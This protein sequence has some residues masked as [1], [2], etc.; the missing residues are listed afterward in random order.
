[1][2]KKSYYVISILFLLWTSPLLFAKPVEITLWTDQ[3][4]P[5]RLA[6]I[7]YILN[8]F[9]TMHDQSIKVSIKSYN[10]NHISKAFENA[11]AN[12]KAPSI[13]NANLELLVEF[14]AK[15][16]LEQT[17]VSKLIQKKKSLEFFQG[18]LK[19]AAVPEKK[20]RY[21]AIPYH[22]WLQGIWYRKDWFEKAKLPEPNTLKRIL[23]AAKFFYQPKKKQYGILIGSK[24][25][26]YTEQV[27]TH[28]AKSMGISTIDYKNKI[29]FNSQKTVK[30]LKYYQELNKYAP[31]GKNNWRARDFFFQNKLAMMFYST[32]IM[33]DLAFRHAALNSLTSKNFAE[34]KGESFDANFLNKVGVIS[35]IGETKKASYGVIHGLGVSK[36]LNTKQQD[37][38]NK[39]L[40]FLFRQDVYITWLHM[41]PGGM[42]PIIKKTLE[43]PMF[44]QDPIGLYHRYK[45]EKISKIIHSVDQVVNFSFT[46][47][48]I[49][50]FAHRFS[51]IRIIPRMIDRVLFQKMD[52]KKSVLIASKEMQQELKNK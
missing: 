14:G 49:N 5:T 47:E 24:V 27:F 30:L 46:K 22:S 3:T 34:L 43:S 48:G 20:N 15:G 13:I 23:S 2:R 40:Y 28:L 29:Q 25:D 45:R 16:Y 42:L 26:L 19:I 8:A 37:A 36:N 52:I 41:A 32:H 1:M 44:Y 21:Y 7:H 39:L 50:P 12:S 51:N 10:E 11:V 18:P 4:K 38:V 33:D 6:T 35:T 9:E 17:L 31:K